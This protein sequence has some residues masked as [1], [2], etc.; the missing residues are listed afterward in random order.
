MQFLSFAITG[1]KKKIKPMRFL[2]IIIIITVW[3]ILPAGCRFPVSIRLV[4]QIDSISKKWV[5][6][7][8]EGVFE[9]ELYRKGLTLVL[10]GETDIPEAKA[11]IISLL[12]KRKTKFTDS[13]KVL[14]DTSEIKNQ[15]ALVC[16]SVCNIRSEPNH[17]AELISQALMGTPVK[18]LKKKN[19]WY[20]IQMPDRYLGW[21]DSEALHFLTVSEFQNWK[22]SPRVI[23]TDKTG[24]IY[25]IDNE[26][27]KIVSDIVAG[28]ILEKTGEYADFFTVK[29]PD[30][31]KGMINKRNSAD[32][33]SWAAETRPEPE[34]LIETGLLLN[35]IPYL[36][37]GTSVKGMD[38]SGFVKTVYFM[39]GLILARD[40]SLQ[41]RHGIFTPNP[42]P[43]DSLKKGDLLYFGTLREG[44]MKATHVGMYIGNTEYIHSSGMVRINSLDSTRFNFSSYRYSTFL[45]AGRIIGSFPAEG[46]QLIE[47]HLWYFN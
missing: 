42:V 15:W 4:N 1:I 45:G 39:N 12:E 41:I 6:D 23:F 36:W 13:L 30:G 24:E 47:N 26:K 11:D 2:L 27:I 7:S 17:G 28:C 20:F 35:G 38:C 31:R 21:T 40:V 43:V 29:L 22:S 33:A 3:M 14:P 46:L 44:K 34:K 5:P 8:R 18:I 10:K 19:S 32:F 9:I 37:G 25:S 16:V